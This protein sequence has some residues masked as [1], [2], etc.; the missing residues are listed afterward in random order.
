M[1]DRT[2][3]VGVATYLRADSPGDSP[4]W[5]FGMYGEVVDVHPDDLKRFDRLNGAGATIAPPLSQHLSD[6]VVEG[7]A[8]PIEDGDAEPPRSGKGSGLDAWIAYAELLEIDV[9]ED[10]TRDDVIALVDES[11]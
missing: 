1:T 11:A 8:R 5:G 6:D 9:P 4:L 2:V 3:G 10:A 7:G